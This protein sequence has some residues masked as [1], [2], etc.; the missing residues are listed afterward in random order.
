MEPTLEFVVEPRL[1]PFTRGREVL[2][3][4]DEDDTFD[5]GLSRED[6]PIFGRSIRNPSILFTNPDKNATILFD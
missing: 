3:A 2:L 1:P 6:F 5:K 4:E